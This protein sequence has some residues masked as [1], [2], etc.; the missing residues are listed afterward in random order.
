MME[1]LSPPI[2]DWSCYRAMSNSLQDVVVV[3][4]GIVGAAIAHELSR[5]ELSV[6][7][8]ER[9]VEAGFG[10]SKANSGIIH[11]GHHTDIRNAQ[12]PPGMVG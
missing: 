8:L 1:W 11:G 2:A 7:L 12:G 4:A 10:T 5:Y 9:E 3:G 6:T